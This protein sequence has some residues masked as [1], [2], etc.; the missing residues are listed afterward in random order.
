MSLAMHRRLRVSV[1]VSGASRQASRAMV[2]DL[3]GRFLLGGS[4][5]LRLVM[6]GLFCARAS[7]A[8]AG[9][10]GA[11]VSGS[12]AGTARQAGRDTPAVYLL[13]SSAWWR[14]CAPASLCRSW[15]PRR[16]APLWSACGSRSDPMSS[17]TS[18]RHHGRE[19][20]S[21]RNPRDFHAAAW[22]AS[23]PPDTVTDTDRG[24]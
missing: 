14:T 1:G 9:R 17:C 2:A 18:S 21:H 3:W 16:R 10:S 22:D 4:S 8:E 12:A 24:Q 7:G 6:L 20:A 19:R 13:E 15:P 5:L 23:M 11:P